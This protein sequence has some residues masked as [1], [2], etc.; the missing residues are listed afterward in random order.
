MVRPEL[1]RRIASALDVSKLTARSTKFESTISFE[2]G[3]G[4][5]AISSP[6]KLIGW[7]HSCLFPL[8]ARSAIDERNDRISGEYRNGRKGLEIVGKD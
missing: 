6:E 4:R 2:S 7:K 5:K 3:K 1:R 8:L